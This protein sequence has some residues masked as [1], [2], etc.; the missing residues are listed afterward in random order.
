MSPILN[1][2]VGTNGRYSY[3]WPAQP[4]YGSTDTFLVTLTSYN[5]AGW[6]DTVTDPRGL[7]AKTFYDNLGRT[8]KSVADYTGGAVG[9]DHD[10]TT[11]YASEGDGHV[12]LAQADLPGGGS[13]G[14]S[15]A[16]HNS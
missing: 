7:M 14:N 12:T 5:P 10:Q 8:I 13:K 3:I 4:G 2:D 1:A 6:V 11:E 9:N 15:D 16:L